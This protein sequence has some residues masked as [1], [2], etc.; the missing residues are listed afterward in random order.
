MEE[1]GLKPCCDITDWIRLIRGLHAGEDGT[2]VAAEVHGREKVGGRARRQATGDGV[3]P[4][5]EGRK[6]SVNYR[7]RLFVARSAI[8]QAGSA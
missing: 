3:D 6:V 8:R 4:G 1:R 2:T 7:P 5:P